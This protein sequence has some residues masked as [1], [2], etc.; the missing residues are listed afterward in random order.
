MDEKVNTGA[1]EGDSTLIQNLVARFPISCVCFKP[2]FNE[3]REIIDFIILHVNAGFETIIGIDH[4]VLLG[5]SIIDVFG[6]MSMECVEDILKLVNDI[7]NRKDQTGEVKARVLGHMY[8]VS[9]L[10]IS[11]DRLLIIFED[12]HSRFFRK[13]Y[14]RTIPRDV[15]TKSILKGQPFMPA[16]ET[17][18]AEK[19]EKP[20]VRSEAM[21]LDNFK[22][23]EIIQSTN[24]CAEAYDAVFRDSLTGL[25][26][27]SFAIEALR[28]YVDHNVIPLS[29]ALGDV[30]GL[31]T[32]N[33]TLGYGAG[34]DILIKIA[35]VFSESC[36]S[37]DVVARWNDGE[38]MLLLPNASQMVAQRII[39]RIQSK[40]NAICGDG[41]QI[42]TFGYAIS[43]KQSRTAE[44]LIR[45][46]EKWIYQKKL[47]INQSHRNSI[48]RLLLSMLHEK[49]AETQEH[50]DRMADHCRW[51]AKILHLSDEMVDDLILLSMLHDIGKIGIPDDVLNKPGALTTEERLMINQH[52]AIG[53]RIA[54]TVPELKQVAAYIL[55]HHER[56][57]G[58]GYP[59]GLR[60]GEIPVPSRIIA[61]VDAFDVMITG[62]KY[63]PART[64]EEAIAEL[65]RCAGTQ[66][67]PD[68]VL[69]FMQLLLKDQ[70]DLTDA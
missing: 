70:N 13:H 22:P 10:F 19:T 17:Q 60:G 36:R 28:M 40:L 53:Y 54:Q 67:D 4:S 59:K 25:Y 30:N 50:S 24:D 55:A 31:R 51:I 9:F 33:E 7:Y 62:R 2:I 44:S 3:H 46:A 35:Q 14:H 29:V 66:F 39:K 8:K 49:S 23:I 5:K 15:I 18:D 56:W 34:D 20:Q 42:V 16:N 6:P 57:D 63:Q 32:I 69:I 12:I 61:V 45:E 68:I 47:L 65:H 1:T 43:E 21:C 58:T 38:F 64:K 41:Y 11:D 52:P 37:D 26:E 27:R 48:I